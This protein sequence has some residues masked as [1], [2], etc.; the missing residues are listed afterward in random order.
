MAAGYIPEFRAGEPPRAADFN[1][2]VATVRDLL[3]GQGMLGITRHSG[4]VMR[5]FSAAGSAVI[6]Y[7]AT[8]EP[9]ATVTETMWQC[10]PHVSVLPGGVATG[11]A[12]A[13]ALA[14]TIA[15]VGV[16]GEIRLTYHGEMDA[17]TMEATSIAHAVVP[18]M[19]PV[20]NEDGSVIYF[21]HG[22]ALAGCQM[23]EPDSRGH[24]QAA[25][26]MWPMPQAPCVVWRHVE[27]PDA[28]GCAA[29][30]PGAPGEQVLAFKWGGYYATRL[31]YKSCMHEWRAGLDKYGQLSMAAGN[32]WMD[33]L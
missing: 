3:A 14:G 31:E 30:L 26:A 22:D 15:P 13:L 32:F 1:A 33:E 2:L 8:G 7:S 10:G 12:D 23:T 17:Q 16:H 27:L 24:W 29:L 9:V 11:A 21:W 25:P 6:R 20:D 5:L 18:W 19:A 28:Q 4:R